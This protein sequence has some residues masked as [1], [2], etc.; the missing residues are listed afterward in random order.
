MLIHASECCSQVQTFYK[1]GDC[2]IARLLRGPCEGTTDHKRKVGT[3]NS[4]VTDVCTVINIVKINGLN[5]WKEY[6]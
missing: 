1:N 3:Y 4:R 6:N 5:I 2:K